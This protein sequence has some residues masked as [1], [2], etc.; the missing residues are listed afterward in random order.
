MIM[1]KKNYSEPRLKIIL[2]DTDQMLLADSNEVVEGSE[3]DGFGVKGHRR[4]F[5]WDDE[6]EEY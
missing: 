1:T 6:D 5:S 3:E 2:I 4:G